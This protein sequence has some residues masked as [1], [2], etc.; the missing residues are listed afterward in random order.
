MV[1]KDESVTR[2]GRAPTGLGSDSD[3]PLA[4]LCAIPSCTEDLELRGCVI[5]TLSLEPE[6]GVDQL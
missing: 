1:P 3:Q 5:L 6:A 2:V 4:Y